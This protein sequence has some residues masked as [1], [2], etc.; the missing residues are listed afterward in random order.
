[1]WPV[2][3]DRTDECEGSVENDLRFWLEV[4]G[5]IGAEKCAIRISPWVD[6]FGSR[7]IRHVLGLVRSEGCIW[8]VERWYRIVYDNVES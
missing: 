6:Y 2:S 4:V 3:N 1:M 8:V 5:A 7:R